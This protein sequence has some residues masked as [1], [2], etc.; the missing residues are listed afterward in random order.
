[1]EENKEFKP[2]LTPEQNRLAEEFFEKNLKLR[3]LKYQRSTDGKKGLY[4]QINALQ[5]D[6]FRIKELFKNKWEMKIYGT[7]THQIV[8]CTIKEYIELYGEE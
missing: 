8:V 6:L 1:M 5:K 4:H 3:M 2:E 7:N